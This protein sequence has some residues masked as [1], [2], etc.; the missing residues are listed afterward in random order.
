MN[1]LVGK[2][3]T[4]EMTLLHLDTGKRLLVTCPQA[5]FHIV[6]N[7]ICVH[8]LRILKSR[9]G[10]KALSNEIEFIIIS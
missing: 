8:R 7:A 5:N 3:N 4:A 10:Y 9:S 1:V 2:K 6:P